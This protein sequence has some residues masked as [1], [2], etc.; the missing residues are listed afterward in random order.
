M[1]R[2]TP[3]PLDP[4]RWARCESLFHQAAELPEAERRALLER[5]CG[6]DP[7]LRSAVERLLAVDAAADAV[8]DT[9]MEALAGRLLA[10]EAVPALP[11]GT[12]VGRYRIVGVLGS[13][14]MGT[15]YRAERADGAYDRQVAIK[16]VR[17][18]RLLADSRARFERERQILG[19]LRHPGIATLVD[20]GVTEAGEAYLA[21]ELI[22]GVSV[23]AFAQREGLG[24]RGRVALAIEVADAVEYAHR[25]L[26]VHRDL[27]P[28]NI[29]VDDQG[30]PKLLDFGI[31]R[32]LDDEVE[33][34]TRTGIVPL[35]P[36]YAAPEQIRG[37]PVTT[38]TDVYALGAVLYQ[39]LT[40]E[41]PLGPVGSRWNDLQRVLEEPPPPLSAA[42]GL[43]R[44]AR[45]ALAG[46]LETIVQKALHKDPARRY[47]SAGG[48][49][50]DLRRYLAGRPIHARP[51]S[52]GYRLTKFGERHRAATL[53]GAALVVAIAIGV[54]STLWQA[55]L[56]RIE[57]E[58]G[59]AV[60]DFLFSLFEGA[61]PDL[62]PGEPVT[63]LELLEA[64][65]ARVDSLAAGPQ[66][67]V[68]LL[69][70]LGLLFGKLGHYDRSEALLRQAVTEARAGLPA[71][72]PAV[73][74]ALDALGI[75]LSR[76]GDLSEAEAVLTEALEVRRTGRA[77]AV[78][79]A[80][81]EGNLAQTIR[82]RGRYAEA[83]SLYR[84]AI[85]RLAATSGADSATFVSEL[86]GL[87]Q[88]YQVMDRREEAE[89]LF[90]TVR[91]LE[92]ARPTERP[93]LAFATHNLGVVLADQDRHDD[94]MAAHR[95]A[96]ALWERLF[97]GGHPEIARSLE[98]IARV[99]E[100]QG[101]WTAADSVYR[102]AIA[103]WSGLYG[104]AASQ[105]ATI[106]ANQANL[107]YFAGDFAAAAAAYRDGIRIWRAND[108]RLLLGAGL[109][110]LGI[111]ERDRG[112]LRAADTL[113]SAALELRRELHGDLHTSVAE[114][115]TAIA[116]L[117]NRQSRH[118]DAERHA[119]NA[120]EQYRQLLDPGHRLAH[121]A[122]LE[123]GIAVA[124]Q[125][126]F[127]EARSLLQPVFDDFRQTRNEKDLGLGRAGLWLGIALAGAGDRARARELI[128]GA[129]PA[130]AALSPD[131]PDRRRAERELARLGR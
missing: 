79:T 93:L 111:I 126:R 116:G 34:V 63:A 55:R 99:L 92:R 19:R 4:A 125:G 61:D 86:M 90:E 84:T 26:V 33:G 44:S 48:L 31:A 124:S 71:R 81:T 43:D 18:E 65:L 3:P 94:A 27:K 85:D 30:H 123:L 104:D 127:A 21:M 36:D 53:V 82:R 9:P 38:A 98:A 37:E 88:V 28:S 100:R 70:T 76:S 25:N 12:I 57:A 77:S 89:A 117:R 69:T 52:I 103:T 129:L 72:D 59:R 45:R 121:Y 23:T 75:Q 47:P 73:G 105:V 110:N 112:E 51:D 80:S 49:A 60:G 78:E 106:R 20:G 67:R 96:L 29:L 62:H 6:D 46:D 22:D 24:L 58:R 130:L 10:V 114:T 108:E 68:D 74:K 131:A 119:R 56:A 122:N 115:H 16:M 109:R 54:G 64:G 113:L 15:V 118:D 40:G 2:S 91:R 120:A 107:R 1:S 39:L 101:R 13:G 66:A 5:E 83:E 17:A 50:E 97:P 11:G 42:K 8:I 41:R 95:E 102:E 14:G 32:L 87:G 35:T 7:E 128:Q